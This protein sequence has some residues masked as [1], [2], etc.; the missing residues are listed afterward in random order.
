MIF[1][2]PLSAR[3]MGAFPV[4][5]A[6]SLALESIFVG[7]QPAYDPNRPIPQAVDIS[8]YTAFYVNLNTLFRNIVGSV[9]GAD[10]AAMLLPSDICEI[11]QA[12]TE[13]ISSLVFEYTAGK[14]KC[15]FYANAHSSLLQAHP[16]ATLRVIKTE[17]KIVYAS[18]MK[19]CV[20][21]FISTN[22]EASNI[23]R[24]D[25]LIQPDLMTSALILTHYAY[26][27]LSHRSFL[28]LDLIESHTGV[29]KTISQWHTKFVN[30]KSLIRIPFNECFIQIFGDSET[31]AEFPQK[32]KE[33]VLELA[34]RYKWTSVTTQPRLIFCFDMLKDKLLAAVLKAMILER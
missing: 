28:K 23:K 5:I 19:Q 21:K 8:K 20:D 17:K 32:S 3:T 6:T 27:L 22:K 31:F 1:L 33:L 29:L 16:Y 34:E 7:T 13:L 26:D 9:S 4:S 12:E 30:G 10:A 15:V 14:T 2:N 11:L 24:F 18:L 25:R